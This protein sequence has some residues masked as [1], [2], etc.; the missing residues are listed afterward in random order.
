MSRA[1][2]R[3]AH[4][5]AAATTAPE[6][7]YRAAHPFTCAAS[8]PSTPSGPSASACLVSSRWAANPAVTARYWS[9]AI[10]ADTA[11]LMAR[12]GV[13][14]GTSSSGRPSSSA[15]STSAPGISS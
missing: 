8:A 3:P 4:S 12:K 11:L 7:S 9:A 14:R 13:R 2:R 15:A 5:G 10:A 6:A 1:A